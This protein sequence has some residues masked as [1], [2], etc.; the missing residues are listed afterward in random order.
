M[1]KSW[2]NML[3]DEYLGR[4][5]Q[6]TSPRSICETPSKGMFLVRMLR[7]L[8]VEMKENFLN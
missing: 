7:H 4:G 1:F 6:T 3:K 2:I 8:S 5:L